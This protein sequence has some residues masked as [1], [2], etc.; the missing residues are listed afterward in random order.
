VAAPIIAIDGP[1]GS[2][3][4]STSRGVA[5]RLHLRYVDTGAMYRAMTWWMLEHRVDV[6]DPAAVAA[7]CAEPVVTLRD[8]PSDPG[9]EVDGMDVSAPIRGRAVADA[10]S[11]VAA[12][13]QVRERL[14]ARQRELVVDAVAHGHGVVMEGRDIG[15]VVLPEADLKVYLTADVEARASRRAREEAE[16]E[17]TGSVSAAQANLQAR[18]ALDSTRSTS[19]LQQAPGAVVIDGTDLTLDQVIDAVIA[20]LPVDLR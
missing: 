6:H 10:V 8:D 13:P 20:A 1:S 19:P 14:V 3:K 7:R 12:V 9:V 16:R 4:S 18:D 5:Q 17:G 15:T 11:L 2:G